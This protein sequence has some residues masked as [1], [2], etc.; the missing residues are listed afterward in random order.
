LSGLLAVAAYIDLNPVRA[1]IVDDPKD[2]R[3][4]SYSAAVAGNV[5]A[6][7]GIGVCSGA[8]KKATWRSVG[9]GYRKILFGAGAEEVGGAGADGKPQRTRRGF[10][11]KEV[12]AVWK[13]GGKQTLAQVLRCRVAYF[14]EGIALGGKGF[15]S[16]WGEGNKQVRG[17]AKS[18]G[19]VDLGGLM[20]FGPRKDDAIRAPG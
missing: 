13:A 18:V 16:S 15:L 10:T 7:K 19:G 4:C 20:F 1:G 12:E 6:R 2:Y 14:T 9:A 3:W 17:T 11:Q 8:A 5:A